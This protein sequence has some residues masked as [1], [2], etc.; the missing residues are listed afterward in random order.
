M[1][2]RVLLVSLLIISFESMAGGVV[3]ELKTLERQAEDIRKVAITCYVELKVFKKSAWGNDS[4]I[5]Y[6]EF[7]KPMMQK[8]KAN[9]EEQSVEFKRYSKD[10]DAS[11]KRI[12]RGLRY[13]VSTK[14]YLQSVK[15]IRKSINSL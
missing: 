2:K 10:P 6:R 15:N 5:E 8:F 11:R 13:L 9:L 14:E 1:L 4:C 3:S 12:L 7:D